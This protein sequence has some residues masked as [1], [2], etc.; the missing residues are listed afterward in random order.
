[1]IT[2]ARELTAKYECV[3]S[4]IEVDNVLAR[5]K[6]FNDVWGFNEHEAVLATEATI[7]D[8]HRLVNAVV[9]EPV[10]TRNVEQVNS[11]DNVRRITMRDG[12]IRMPSE[13]TE[14]VVIGDVEAL[15]SV[16]RY[17]NECY[18]TEEG[19]TIDLRDFI[20]SLMVDAVTHQNVTQSPRTR[21]H[22][23]DV[24]TAREHQFNGVLVNRLRGNITPR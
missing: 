3:E 12:E 21:V 6:M 10:N 18:Q 9:A 22:E 1:M 13:N 5:L 19:I 24:L 4:K 14:P 15:F 17:S 11:I 2:E 8:K 20:T 7:I 16:D 23:D